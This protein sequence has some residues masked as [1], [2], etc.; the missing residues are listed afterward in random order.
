MPNSDPGQDFNYG[1][2]VG[3]VE[4]LDARM[5]RHENWIGSQIGQINDKLD[6][7]AMQLARGSG[8]LKIIQVMWTAIGG[9]T[10]AAAVL[11]AMLHLTTLIG[12]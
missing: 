11:M 10:V 1:I 9:A 2:L 6:D 3:K 4:M 7:V 5:T 8:G 12:H